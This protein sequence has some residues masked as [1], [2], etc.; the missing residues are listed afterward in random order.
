[1]SKDAANQEHQGNV[2]YGTVIGETEVTNVWD[3]DSEANAD[4][5]CSP[6]KVCRNAREFTFEGISDGDE[7]LATSWRK[8]LKSEGKLS[9]D[10]SPSIREIMLGNTDA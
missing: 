4:A 9:T 1:V 7:D 10:E 8:L 5:D 6:T 2:N 3:N